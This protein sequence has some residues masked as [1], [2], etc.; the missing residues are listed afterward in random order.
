MFSSIGIGQYSGGS[1]IHFHGLSQDLCVPL[2]LAMPD[3]IEFLVDE[4]RE[5][6]NNV[7]KMSSIND[8]KFEDLF[9]RISYNKSSKNK[10][11]K[12]KRK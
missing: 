4:N 8:L 1:R 7:E 2:G 5:E 10:T 9:Q 12:K 11:R 3:R 6:Y